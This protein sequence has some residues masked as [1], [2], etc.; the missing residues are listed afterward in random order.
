[1]SVDGFGKLGGLRILNNGYAATSF[2]FRQSR[3]TVIERPGKYYP[4]HTST[5][6]A[7][8]PTGTLG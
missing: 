8:R 7:G 2:D 3:D 5:M 6:I 1:M 4:G